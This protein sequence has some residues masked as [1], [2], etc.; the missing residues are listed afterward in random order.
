MDGFSFEEQNNNRFSGENPEEKGM[1][2]MLVKWGIAK[3]YKQGETFLLIGSL[4]LI[5]ISIYIF[6][7]NLN[8]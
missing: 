1:A 5:A 4:V 6:S 3:T 7:Q 8:F 2:G